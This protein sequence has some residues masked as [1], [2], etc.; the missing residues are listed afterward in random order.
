MPPGVFPEFSLLNHS[1]A[2]NT[3]APVLLKDRLLLR[4]AVAVPAGN[5]LTTSYLGLAGGMPSQQRQQLLQ[6]H[7]GFVCKC[8]RCKVGAHVSS[9]GWLNAHTAPSH[10]LCSCC[11]A[12]AATFCM[13]L[14]SHWVLHVRAITNGIMVSSG[15]MGRQACPACA[16]SP[17]SVPVP[18][19]PPSLS[20]SHLFCSCPIHSP[21]TIKTACSCCAARLFAANMPALHPCWLISGFW[22]CAS[23]VRI[24]S[25]Q[26]SV[27]T[28]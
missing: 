14:C 4:T 1:C 22:G 6:Q 25:P 18:I 12:F 28:C 27:Q 10:V 5:E 21:A 7:Y 15:L 3:A 23:F 9:H 20:A 16:A 13:S 8:H 24:C 17:A 11:P 2:P 26:C 19:S